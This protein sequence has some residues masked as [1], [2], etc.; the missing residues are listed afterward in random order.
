MK[1]GD[2]YYMP[3]YYDESHVLVEVVSIE[4]PYAMVCVVEGEQE[5]GMAYPEIRSLVPVDL[6]NSRLIRALS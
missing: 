1:E 5:S 2:R 6:F 3:T 4:K